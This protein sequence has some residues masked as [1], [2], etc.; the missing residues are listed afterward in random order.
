MSYTQ[1]IKTISTEIN[2]FISSHD[3]Y[4]VFL[5]HISFIW[6]QNELLGF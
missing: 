6:L 2:L 1:I 5:K 4:D 3:E